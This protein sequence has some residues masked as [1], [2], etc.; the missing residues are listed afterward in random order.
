MDIL[1]TLPFDYTRPEA[2]ELRD[3]LANLYYRDTDI[4]RLADAINF[5]RSEIPFRDTAQAT[6][7]DLLS[8]A[9][10]R[11]TLRTLI[12]YILEDG[13]AG[14]ISGR[15]TE[16]LAD[17]PITDAPN[18]KT[19]PHPVTPFDISRAEK[20]TGSRPTFLDLSFFHRCLAVAPAVVRVVSVFS[21]SRSTGTGVLISENLVLTNHHVLFDWE[22]QHERAKAV[23][24]W[25]GYE[26]A[27]NGKPRRHQIVSGRTDRILG[28]PHYDW[29]TIPLANSPS[30]DFRPVSPYLKSTISIGDGVCII[31]HVHGLPKQIAF[32][33]NMMVWRN[34]DFLLYLTDTDE[35]SSGSPVFDENWRLIGLHRGHEEAGTSDRPEVVNV[36]VSMDTIMDGLHSLRSRPQAR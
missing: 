9:R 3:L 27:S 21:K 33:D 19:L 36:G 11:T 23:Q 1:D 5:P 34:N 18:T 20:I 8:E 2:R 15:L 12:E 4:V 35:G 26:T 29:A 22:R 25:F 13:R 10:N 30:S 7:H 32:Q 28:D 31:Q 6:W 16:L 17:A 14:A 24:I